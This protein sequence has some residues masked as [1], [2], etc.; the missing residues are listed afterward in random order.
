MVI[1]L[2][3]YIILQYEVLAIM[4][5]TTVYIH[6]AGTTTIAI[7]RVSV[8]QTN[9]PQTTIQPVWLARYRAQQCKT[10][11]TLPTEATMALIINSDAESVVSEAAITPRH[12][13]SN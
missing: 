7:R 11:K 1:W 2:Y 10:N 6:S 5:A 13:V 9:K 4:V 12:C 3:C 8:K